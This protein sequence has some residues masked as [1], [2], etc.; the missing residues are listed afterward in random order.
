[1]SSP[2]KPEPGSIALKLNALNQLKMFYHPKLLR[3]FGLAYNGLWITIISLNSDEFW[4][5]RALHIK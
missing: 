5:A 1:M 3:G 2:T 4:M